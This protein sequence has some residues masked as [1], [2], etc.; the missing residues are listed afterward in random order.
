MRGHVF[1]DSK[2]RYYGLVTT[3]AKNEYW[4]EEVIHGLYYTCIMYSAISW[5][6][7]RNRRIIRLLRVTSI[8]LLRILYTL[9]KGIF[10]EKKS[11][12]TFLSEFLPI[13]NEIAK[14]FNSTYSCAIVQ[15]PK[16]AR[17]PWRSRVVNED[18]SW[19][20]ARAWK[21]YRVKAETD[22]L[23]LTRR[24]RTRRSSSLLFLSLSVLVFHARFS[25]ATLFSRNPRKLT[26]EYFKVFKGSAREGGAPR[27]RRAKE[28]R[29]WREGALE[30]RDSSGL[31]LYSRYTLP[32]SSPLSSIFLSF[33][34]YRNHEFR[35]RRH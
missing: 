5:L 31:P 24:R 9:K 12:I 13:L 22:F 17:F 30:K 29:W 3:P 25:L 23:R 26:R 21:N 33:V 8:S 16:C 20:R 27:C 2:T 10:F 32:L 34:L 4:K 11:K 14:N 6:C 19:R 18:E 15:S 1:V 28:T 7:C 35:R